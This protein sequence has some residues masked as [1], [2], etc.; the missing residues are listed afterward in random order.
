MKWAGGLDGLKLSFHTGSRRSTGLAGSITAVGSGWR[1][2]RFRTT[3][4]LSGFAVSATVGGVV[5]G[6]RMYSFIDVM[7]NCLNYVHSVAPSGVAFNPSWH[8]TAVGA[9]SSAV[10][11]HVASRRW[12]SFFR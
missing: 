3:A 1:G 7:I 11:V 8:L 12:L 9:V 2:G 5:M 6:L 10:A 4:G